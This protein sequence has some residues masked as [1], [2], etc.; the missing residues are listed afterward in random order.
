MRFRKVAVVSALFLAFVATSILPTPDAHARRYKSKDIVDTVLYINRKSGE[1]D[2]LIKALSRAGLV[3]ALRGGPFTVFAPTDEAFENLYKA[4]GVDGIDDLTEEQVQTLLSPVLLYH[5][6]EGRIS[7]RAWYKQREL[8]MLSG[9]F[10][11]LSRKRWA[12]FINDARIISWAIP[13]SNG[14]IYVIDKV[15]L[16]KSEPTDS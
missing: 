7:Y 3:E 5:V 15:I 2:E 9:Q 16:P 12:F 13:A 10:S 8:E 14:N 4:L 11:H 1:F 6:T